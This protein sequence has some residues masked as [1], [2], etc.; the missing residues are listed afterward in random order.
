LLPPFKLLREIN[1]LQL[2][3]TYNIKIYKTQKHKKMAEMAE[4]A[5]IK[6]VNVIITFTNRVTYKDTNCLRHLTSEP[7]C[8]ENPVTAVLFYKHY[9]I[10]YNGEKTWKGTSFTV[11]KSTDDLFI[12]ISNNDED[13]KKTIT[14]VGPYLH[15]IKITF[16]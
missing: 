8:K 12:I 15:K 3:K 13:N 2:S 14:A 6:N 11:D 7:D 1:N 4:M 10:L 9:I 5:E 16:N